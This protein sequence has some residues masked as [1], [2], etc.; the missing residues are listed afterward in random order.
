MMRGRRLYWM[1]NSQSDAV[2]SINAEI[3]N[4][5]RSRYAAYQWKVDQKG[6][7]L[8]EPKSQWG[9]AQQ[10]GTQWK[11]LY[12]RGL[13]FDS[14]VDGLLK[15]VREESDSRGWSL[16]VYH[17]PTKEEIA[18]ITAPAATVSQAVK[19][20][21]N[22]WRTQGGSNPI[23]MTQWLESVDD[24]IGQVEILVALRQEVQE[25]LLAGLEFG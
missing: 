8:G 10:S 18:G 11:W 17:E 23:V 25:R 21:V 5:G 13:H 7:H 22:D 15:D 16:K 12:R 1:V 3:E 4:S 20:L 2:D 14:I 9:V 19:G 24:A 6:Y